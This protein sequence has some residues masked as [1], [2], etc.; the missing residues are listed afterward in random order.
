MSIIRQGSVIGASLHDASAASVAGVSASALDFAA[1]DP[2]AGL[3]LK[4]ENGSGTGTAAV[5]ASGAQHIDGLLSGVRWNG[6]I[7]Y[8]DPDSALDYQASHPENFTNLSQLS[9]TQLAMVHAVLNEATYTQLPGAYS[10]SV[11]GLTNLSVTYGASGS[12]NSTIRLVNTSDPGTAYAYYPST[13]VWGGDVFF[14]PSGDFPTMGNYDAFTIIHEIGHALGLKHGHETNVYGALPFDTDS[15]EYSVMTYR[16]YVG[17]DAQFVYNETWGYAQT[18]MMYDIA[19]LQYMYGADFNL[20]SGNTVY[21]WNPT[22]GESYVNGT[23]AID[24]GANRIFQTVWDGNGIDTYDLSNYATNLS[25]DLNPGGYSTFS[26]AQRA[27]LGGGPNGGYARGNVFNALQYQNDARSLIENAT[28]GSGDDSIVG[29]AAANVLQGGAGNDTLRGNGGNDSLYGG[30]GN[31]LLEGGSGVDYESGGDGNDVFEFHVG[32]TY[33][34]TVDGGTGTD[35]FDFRAIGGGFSGT[36]I[37]ISLASGYSDIGGTMALLNL[38]NVRGSDSAEAIEG[39]NAAN[40]LQGYGGND[41]M[42]GGGGNDTLE[43]G[44]GNDVLGGGAGNDRH[45]GGNGDDTVFAGTGNDTAIGGGG[46]DSL[47]GGA[48]NDRFQGD[49]GNDTVLGGSGNDTALGGAGNDSLVGE[50][51]SDSLQGQAGNDTLYGGAGK[52]LLQGGGGNDRFVFIAAGESPLGAACDVLQAGG[53]GT[54][55][56][57]AG[58]APGD[59]IDLSG[60]DANVTAAGNQAFIFGGTGKGHVWCVNSG[61]ITSVFANVDN[62]AAAEFQLNIYDTGVLA[63]AYRAADF[64]L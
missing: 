28:G 16:S 1:A 49:A 37:E 29:N 25:I 64:I 36:G 11:E 23:L 39:N 5:G 44:N 31:D 7:T 20:N 24:P 58:N 45:V 60:I 3:P 22:S 33:P 47:V 54:A 61:N 30:A 17:S 13:G 56:D 62:D 41:T 15:M 38:E 63:G 14:G 52:D 2:F 53:G 26:S 34:N 51:G 4:D 10:Y 40:L 19:A 6:A 18:F 43:G 50:A 21:S 59:R 48:G 46:N 12:G 55:F 27:Y 32:F 57:G 42:G 8:S 35:T 9:A